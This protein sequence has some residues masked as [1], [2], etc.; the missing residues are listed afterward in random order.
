MRVFVR[1]WRRPCVKLGLV[2]YKQVAFR[3]IPPSYWERTAT[4]QVGPTT[5][6]LRGTLVVVF[7]VINRPPGR[8]MKLSIRIFHSK[9]K[10]SKQY[11]YQYTN[12]VYE[13]MRLS[14]YIFHGTAGRRYR[15]MY[16][17][18]GPKS[19][20]QISVC[21]H[22]NRSRPAVSTDVLLHYHERVGSSNTQPQHP[23]R[24]LRIH[25]VPGV[26]RVRFAIK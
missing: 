26:W 6:T 24:T 23:R 15:L 8:P 5:W 13:P 18:Y 12:R 14:T 19:W 22:V 9:I 21:R 2:I 7:E 1:T 20:F 11:Q 25:V 4:Q 3:S 10:N 17:C 16:C